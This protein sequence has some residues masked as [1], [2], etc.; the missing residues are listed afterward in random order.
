MVHKLQNTITSCPYCGELIEIVVDCS[1]ECQ[2]YIEDC[3][4]CCRPILF[5]VVSSDGD[6]GSIGVQTEDE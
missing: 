4:V 6:I 3:S 2:E 1:I 5:N